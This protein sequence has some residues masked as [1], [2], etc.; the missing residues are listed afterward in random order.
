MGGESGNK[1]LDYTSLDIL[2]RKRLF[3]F[4]RGLLFK[5]WVN[6]FQIFRPLQ[7]EAE[8]LNK[9]TNC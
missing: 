5:V 8:V 9:F 2:G 3:Q 1:Q 6:Q 4:D 7:I